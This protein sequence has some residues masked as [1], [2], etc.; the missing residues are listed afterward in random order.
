MGDTSGSGYPERVVAMGATIASV[1]VARRS[2]DLVVVSPLKDWVCAGCGS[3]DEDLLTMDDRGPLCM[4][5]ADL[6]HLVF[7]PRGDTALTR[8][9]RKHSRLSAVVVRFSRARKRYERQGVLVEEAA[10]V[11]AEAECLADEDARA[12]RRERETERRTNEDVG[13]QRDL[14]SAIA[15]LFP[16]CPHARLEEIARHT[17]ERGS[18]RVGR[19]AAGRA[20]DP[21]AITLA[22]VAAVRHGDTDYDDLL[23]AGVDRSDA[24]M[25]VRA[26]VEETLERWRGTDLPSGQAPGN[27][28]DAARRREQVR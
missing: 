16:E 15:R 12:R 17:A 27:P 14:A 22:V 24:R 18:G 26:A 19:T 10:I 8:R 2:P 7:L 25:R 20:L 23:M 3:A 1:S 9:A 13:F 21:Q 11:Q 5:C 4:S 6:A 28:D